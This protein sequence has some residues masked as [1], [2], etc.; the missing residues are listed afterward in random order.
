LKDFDVLSPRF[1]VNSDCELQLMQMHM[2]KA[3]ELGGCE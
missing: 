1:S 2:H 3:F